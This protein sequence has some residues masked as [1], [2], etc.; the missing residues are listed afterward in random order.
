MPSH[1]R[2]YPTTVPCVFVHPHVLDLPDITTSEKRETAHSE[3]P[4]D[5]VQFPWKWKR[6]SVQRIGV[7]EQRTGAR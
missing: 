7:E 4:D 5:A 6:G 3:K 2:M 1:A